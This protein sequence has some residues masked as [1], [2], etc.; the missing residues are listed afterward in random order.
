MR[1]R[2]P[3]YWDPLILALMVVL[4]GVIVFAAWNIITEPDQVECVVRMK[5]QP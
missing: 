3:G 5:A 2:E 1:T 4:L